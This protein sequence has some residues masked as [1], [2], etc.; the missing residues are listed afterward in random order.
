M[1]QLNSKGMPDVCEGENQINSE[2]MP[3]ERLEMKRVDEE[4]AKMI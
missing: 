3:A 4:M 2:G 1:T